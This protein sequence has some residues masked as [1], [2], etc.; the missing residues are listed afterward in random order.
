MQLRSVSLWR[1]RGTAA[2]L[3]LLLVVAVAPSR[4]QQAVAPSATSGVAAVASEAVGP[5]VSAKPGDNGT[6]PNAA[7]TARWPLED[8]PQ[9]TVGRAPSPPESVT[10]P[11]EPKSRGWSALLPKDPAPAGKAAA[12]ALAAS[13]T[14]QRAS[15]AHVAKSKSVRA[16]KVKSPRANVTQRS[17]RSAAARPRTSGHAKAARVTQGGAKAHRPLALT[18]PV[19]RTSR[20][21][22]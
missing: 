14:S 10:V 12:G 15:R 20:R 1:W 16:T 22:S 18:P 8:T 9:H 7:V 17:Q 2:I 21:A 19:L 4:A 13:K 5:S 6:A 11:E 3:P